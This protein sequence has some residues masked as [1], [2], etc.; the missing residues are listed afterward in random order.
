MDDAVL[1]LPAF[2]N[3]SS[4]DGGPGSK[5]AGGKKISRLVIRDS[6]SCRGVFF[7]AQ[8]SLGPGSYSVGIFFSV[9]F[10]LIG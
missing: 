9:G 2:F 6:S 10:D 8:F 3:R 4:F 1:N 7:A 5:I